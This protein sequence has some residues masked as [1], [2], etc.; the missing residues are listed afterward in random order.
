MYAEIT[1]MKS[2]HDL[3]RVLRGL[4]WK[5]YASALLIL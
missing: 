5:T 4:K 1:A 3:T 2:L